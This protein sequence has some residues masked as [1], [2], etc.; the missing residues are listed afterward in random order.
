MATPAW[1]GATPGSPP[2]AAQ[3][4]QFLGTH[5]STYAYT[6]AEHDNQ[7]TA[8][9]GAVAS[10]GSYVAQSFTAGATYA[11]GRVLVTLALTGSP[12]PLVVT[13]Q[14]ST[15]SAPS[16]TVLAGPISLA[17]GFVPASAGAVSIPLSWAV[18]SGTQYWI[19]AT[20][21]GDGSDFYAWSKSSA[22]SGASTSTNGTAWTAQSYGLLFQVWDSTAVLP[23][24]HTVDDAGARWTTLGTNANSQVSSLNEYTAA[25]SGS[26]VSSSR[27]MAYS[28]SQL[29]AVA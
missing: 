3:I 26:Y 18:A 7:S 1:I 11:A 28:G 9:S 5:A 24:V 2:L 29:T 19:V 27:S 22:A 12:P 8:G 16:G 6:G 15:G 21:V 17:P 4:N 10:D 14:S 23:L 13:V 20:A 25:Q